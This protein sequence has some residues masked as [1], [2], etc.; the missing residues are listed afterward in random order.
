MVKG[1]VPSLTSAVLALGLAVHLVVG[2]TSFEDRCTKSCFGDQVARQ[3]PN[4]TVNI[5]QYV[6]A[7]TNI[8]FPFNAPSC[9]RPG[10]V[11]AVDLCR[12]AMNINTSSSS[13][14]TLETWLPRNWT[15]RFLSTGNGGLSGCTL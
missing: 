8:T 14:I 5:V 6:P 9:A 7:G 4:S 11:V 12:V 13:Q 1:A 15:G 3:Y 2:T 10:Q